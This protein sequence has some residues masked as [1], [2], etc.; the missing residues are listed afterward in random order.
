MET[1]FLSIALTIVVLFFTQMILFING[2]NIP[3]KLIYLGKFK[4]YVSNPYT[5]V[6]SMVYLFYF[7]LTNWF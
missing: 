3:I 5:Y 2:I 7:L 6:P 4:L 1:I